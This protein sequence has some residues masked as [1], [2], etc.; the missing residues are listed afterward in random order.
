M[1]VS[2]LWPNNAPGNRRKK[3][4]G[5]ILFNVGV[6]VVNRVYKTYSN[7]HCNCDTHCMGLPLISA[8]FSLIG[9]MLV[10]LFF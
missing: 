4:A 9:K 7:R 8:T 6:L 2:H 10:G 5:R 1:A 3:S